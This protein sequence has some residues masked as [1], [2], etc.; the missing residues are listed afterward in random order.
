MD[1]QQAIRWLY[2]SQQFGMKL[3]LDKPRALL[4]ALG[5]PHPS[6]RFVHVAGTNGKGSTCAFTH[7][8]FGG[9]SGRPIGLFTSPHLIRFNE[10]IRIGTSPI[11]D[12]ALA[13]GLSAIRQVA[14]SLPDHPT[15]FE[16]ALALALW[17]F[18]EQELPWAVIETGLG[19]RL[20]ATNVL[21]PAACA[22]TPIALDHARWLGD[23]LSK[24]A[25]EKAGIIK[26]HTPVVSAP[27][28]PD[29]L[30]VIRQAALHCSAPLHIISPGEIEAVPSPLPLL[31]EH[32]QTNAALAIA[33]T[34]AA[35]KSSAPDDP[36][37]LLRQARWP[38][39]F[40]QIAPGTIADGAHNPHAAVAL[41]N[42]WRSQF[43]GQQATLIYGAVDGHDWQATL[44]ALIPIARRVLLVSP[45]SSRAVSTCQLAAALPHSIPHC[46]C[47]GLKEALARA[48]RFD[49][50]ILITGSLYL[51]G[52]ALQL[53]SGD[54]SD[55]YQIADPLPL[56]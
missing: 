41:A 5:L 36:H 16:L 26:P 31:G 53:F 38:G 2:E 17:W 27:Q 28:H 44:A 19:G 49:S 4:R 9:R 37:Q 47:D 20:D 33:L 54:Q 1:P 15:F 10:R 35:L 12:V 24:I 55:P 21:S 39:R 48:D 22:I 32:Q 3:G 52:Q 8:L 18:R 30:A 6:Q 42:T 25:A 46:P 43:P 45:T 29:A 11:P 7:A 40:D 56:D 13:Q 14:R 23:S 50:P 51:V 34:R